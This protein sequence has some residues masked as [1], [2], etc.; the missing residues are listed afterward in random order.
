MAQLYEHRDVHLMCFLKITI[1]KVFRSEYILFLAAL[2][3]QIFFHKVA[4]ALLNSCS[5]FHLFLSSFDV[6]TEQSGNLLII[7]RRRQFLDLY[8]S[9]AHC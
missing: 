6:F 2:E 8:H 3:I 9:L 1:F 5:K 4:K 7:P